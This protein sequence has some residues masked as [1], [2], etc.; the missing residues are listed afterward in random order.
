M[1]LSLLSAS[2]YDLIKK[3]ST[4][5][6]DDIQDA[7]SK[8]GKRE[9][10]DSTAR[11]ILGTIIESVDLSEKNNL[12]ICQDSGAVLAIVKARS[13]DAFFEIETAIK[14]AL[15]KLTEQGILRQ[16]CVETQTGTNTGNNIGQH[17]PRIHFIPIDGPTQVCIMLKGGGSENVSTQYSLP[18]EG[19]K[20]GRDFAGVQKCILDAVYKAQ[21]KGCAPGILGVC[22]GGDRASGYMI[23]KEQL[24]RK[25]DDRHDDEAIAQ[26]EK[27]VLDLAN[28]LDI[29]P[30]GLSGR[31]TALG[32]KIGTAGRHPACYFVTVSY[33]CWATRRYCVELDDQGAIKKW[34]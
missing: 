15:V 2:M 33:S 28:T 29:G 8:A 19:L 22:I 17:V 9:E 16:N 10:K 5:L 31:S 27:R 20:A 14:R 1:D 13:L 12:P 24:F 32:I 25:L 26:L 4:E 34:L 7:L 3:T 23:A 18:H 21:G 6:P 30:M 11:E